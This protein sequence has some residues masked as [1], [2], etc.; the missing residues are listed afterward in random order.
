MANNIPCGQC[1]NYHALMKPVKK[2]GTISLKRGH[3]LI[4]TIYASNKPGK[5]IYPPGAK[6]EERE[7]G[8]HKIELVTEAE[9]RPYC[10]DAKRRK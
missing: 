6:T 9:V 1:A 3:C 8:Q 7:F 10:S 2:G 5:N 4:R